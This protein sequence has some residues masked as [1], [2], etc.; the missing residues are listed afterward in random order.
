MVTERWDI[1]FVLILINFLC[2][3]LIVYSEKYIADKTIHFIFC[4]VWIYFGTY[5]YND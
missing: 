3:H 1:S 4:N 5:I 2:E